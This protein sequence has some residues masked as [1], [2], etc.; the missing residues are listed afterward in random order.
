MYFL[1]VILVLTMTMKILFVLLSLMDRLLSYG[2]YLLQSIPEKTN[3]YWKT[4]RFQ[5]GHSFFF[6]PIQTIQL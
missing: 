4:N 6:L 5:I 2:I 3:N 1:Y